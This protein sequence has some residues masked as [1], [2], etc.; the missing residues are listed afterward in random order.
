M[1][2][3]GGC[4]VS[5]FRSP[6]DGSL[7]SPLFLIRMLYSSARQC[8]RMPCCSSS[9]NYWDA[10]WPKISWKGKMWDKWWFPFDT[11]KYLTRL[12]LGSRFMWAQ[13]S[14]RISH[15]H[16]CLQAELKHKLSERNKLLSEYEVC[17]F[18]IYTS[19]HSLDA[20]MHVQTSVIHL[21]C[22]D[23][24]N[25]G[26]RTEY[27]SSSNKSSMKLNIKH[28]KSALDGYVNDIR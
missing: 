3:A 2:E 22:H 17:S 18:I 6:L 15:C 12:T 10:T 16:I 9:R 4:S 23:S 27:C 1:D 19:L 20:Y 26:G 13:Y 28:T 8:R 24:S 7:I 25:W 5:V 14:P 21:S 11:I